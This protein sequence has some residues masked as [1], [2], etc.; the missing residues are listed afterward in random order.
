M[1]VR[2]TKVVLIP[3]EYTSLV[4]SAENRAAFLDLELL[5]TILSPSEVEFYRKINLLALDLGNFAMHFSLTLNDRTGYPI[6]YLSSPD[7]ANYTERLSAVEIQRLMNLMTNQNNPEYRNGQDI[8]NCLN[9][10][11][12]PGDSIYLYSV[13]QD[14]TV[15]FLA[16][17]QWRDSPR[18]S[19]LSNTEVIYTALNKLKLFKLGKSEEAH[20]GYK[21]YV[22]WTEFCGRLFDGYL[23]LITTSSRKLS[24]YGI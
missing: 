5:K 17:S 23:D 11:K 22:H 24:S 13:Y 7:H 19:L 12:L 3:D 8:I 20:I 1:T 18:S 2:P 21:P 4:S 10:G 14:E 6:T 15:V 16:L 9:K